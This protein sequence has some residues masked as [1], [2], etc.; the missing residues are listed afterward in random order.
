MT[1]GERNTKRY[2]AAGLSVFAF[3]LLCVP[4]VAGAQNLL[5]IVQCGNPGEPACDFNQL[6]GMAQ[7]IINILM[8]VFAAPI[9]TVLFA[10]AGFLYVTASADPSQVGKAKGIFMHVLTGLIIALGAWLIVNL[11]TTTLLK[12]SPTADTILTPGAIQG[13]P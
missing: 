13:N 9:A 10:W 4:M 1:S 6:V 11:I 12:G 5:P 3:A 2:V 7:R 8:F